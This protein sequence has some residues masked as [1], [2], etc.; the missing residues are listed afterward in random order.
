M[1]TVQWPYLAG[2]VLSMLC[3]RVHGKVFWSK[4][5]KSHVSTSRDVRGS[6]KTM[7]YII[8]QP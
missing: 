5:Q 2:V 4:P 7:G 6:S 3:A 8:Q 1:L